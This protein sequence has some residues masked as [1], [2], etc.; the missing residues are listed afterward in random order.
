[1][2]GTGDALAKVTSMNFSGRG[3]TNMRGY[4][5]GYGAGTQLGS[6]LQLPAAGYGCSYAFTAT[7]D[8]RLRSAGSGCNWLLRRPKLPDNPA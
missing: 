2:D 3:S 6:W 4:G 1:M 5:N 8:L 7:L